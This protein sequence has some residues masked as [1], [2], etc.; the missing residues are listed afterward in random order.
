MKVTIVQSEIH[1][2]I[3]GY[4]RSL[5]DVKT[6]SRIIIQLRATRGEDGTTADIDIVPDDGS[7]D[8]P[9]TSNQAQAPAPVVSKSSTAV[10]P[11]AEPKPKPTPAPAPEPVAEKAPAS[12]AEQIEQVKGEAEAAEQ[13]EEEVARAADAMDLNA[14][15]EAAEEP[16]A[17]EAAEEAPAR[18]SLFAGLKSKPE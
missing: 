18:Q 9:A 4:V 15:V 16:A 8:Q 6:G 14:P 5:I 3:D 17:E 10:K 7:E 2:A 13:S 11:K 12:T 1:A